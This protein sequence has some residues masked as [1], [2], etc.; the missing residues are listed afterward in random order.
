MDRNIN[1]LNGK[2]YINKLFYHEISLNFCFLKMVKYVQKIQKNG[3]E[4]DLKSMHQKVWFIYLSIYL[5][6]YWWSD[7]NMKN[8]MVRK[9]I[10]YNEGRMEAESDW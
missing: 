5:F 10:I 1:S 4:K 3:E 2:R 6:Y 7:K 9:F 8:E